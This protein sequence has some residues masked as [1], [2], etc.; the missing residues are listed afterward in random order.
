MESAIARTREH[1]EAS[2]REL[3]WWYQHFELPGGVWTGDGTSPAYFPEERWKLFAD[4]LP[5]NLAGKTVL[6]VGGNADYFSIQMKRRGAKRCVLVDAYLE[7]TAQARFAAKQF[8]VKLKIVTEDIH[9]FCLTTDE[10][11]DLCC[12]WAPSTT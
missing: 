2:V 6:D 3:G 1:V 10:R 4:Y 7:F 8:G 12:S 5:A 9:T 11:F